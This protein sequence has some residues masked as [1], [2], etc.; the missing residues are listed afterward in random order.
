MK[1]QIQ[2]VAIAIA[3]ALTTLFTGCAS[4]PQYVVREIKGAHYD[5][6]TGYVR[7]NLADGT[8][9][10]IQPQSDVWLDNVSLVPACK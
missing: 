5:N 2:T 8:M 6:T 3:I 1:H 4:Q 9:C 10:A 7:V